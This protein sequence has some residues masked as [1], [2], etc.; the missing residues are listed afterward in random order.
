[1]KKKLALALI[2]LMLMAT[3]TACEKN[4]A[5]SQTPQDSENAQNSAQNGVTYFYCQADPSTIDSG[6]MMLF[7][8]L[9][10]SSDRSDYPYQ[11]SLGFGDNINA[12][13]CNWYTTFS[14]F[15]DTQVSTKYK[16]ADLTPVES[17]TVTLGG[18]LDCL[19]LT[20]VSVDG[21]TVKNMTLYPFQI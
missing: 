21:A 1:M 3:L 16:G 18:S 5:Q 2:A 4:S 15:G 12:L 8:E 13:N 6:S 14:G 7:A 10:Y 11:L 19:E 17:D 9:T 20:I